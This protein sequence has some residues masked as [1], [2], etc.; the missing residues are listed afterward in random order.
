LRKIES[1]L[2]QYVKTYF[3]D[4]NPASGGKWYFINLE[5]TTRLKGVVL[6]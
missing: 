2:T 6:W 3:S 5:G 4:I 1:F